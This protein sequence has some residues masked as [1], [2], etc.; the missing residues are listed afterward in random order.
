MSSIVAEVVKAIAGGTFIYVALVEIILE[1]FADHQHHH[2]KDD[3]PVDKHEDNK[4]YK[5]FGFVLLGIGMMSI[6]SLWHSH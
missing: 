6:F 4:R 1:E 5:K 3:E 2:I